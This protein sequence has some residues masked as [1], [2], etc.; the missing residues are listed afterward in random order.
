METLNRRVCIKTVLGSLAVAATGVPALAALPE[1][2]EKKSSPRPG[3]GEFCSRA[4]NVPGFD[5]LFR[6]AFG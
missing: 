1:E 5:L 2:K 6:P 4:E 3:A